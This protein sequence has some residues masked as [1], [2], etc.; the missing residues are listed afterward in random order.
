MAKILLIQTFQGIGDF[1]V[2]LPFQKELKRIFP[3]S[4]VHALVLGHSRFIPFYKIT[5]HIDKVIVYD[6][7]GKH[8]GLFNQ[9]RLLLSLRR[10]KYDYGFNFH[11]AKRYILAMWLSGI[12]KT[13]G[14]SYSKFWG[15]FLDI[16]IPGDYDSEFSNKFYANKTHAIVNNLYFLKKWGGDYSFKYT[17]NRLIDKNKL[18]VYFNIEVKKTYIAISPGSRDEKKRWPIKKFITLCKKIKEKYDYNLVFIG[19]PKEGERFESLKGEFPNDFFA[20]GKRFSILSSAAI[21]SESILLISN[22]QGSVHIASALAV[23]AISIGPVNPG[24]WRPW[25]KGSSYLIKELECSKN[26]KGSDLCDDYRCCKEISVESVFE[27]VKETLG[28]V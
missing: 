4:E 12:K 2:T 21:I 24:V 7:F 3:D 26:C 10:E 22:D 25:S 5:P 14:Y 11:P 17:V 13:I 27:K 8:S 9:F 6:K 16:L 15:K 28:Y 18:S 1:M 23:P 20:M 19:S